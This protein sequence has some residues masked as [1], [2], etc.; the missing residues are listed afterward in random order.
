M[1]ET[2]DVPAAETQKLD[3]AAMATLVTKFDTCVTN[4]DAS[5]T[6]IRGQVTTL[7]TEGWYGQQGPAAFERYHTRWSANLTEINNIIMN[8]SKAVNL[9]T[10]DFLD[11][12]VKSGGFGDD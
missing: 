5:I 2:P 10:Q 3:D 1:P 12:D 8:V 9:Q 11:W 7:V 4:Y 6:A